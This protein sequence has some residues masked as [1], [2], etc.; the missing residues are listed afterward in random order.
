MGRRSG[1]KLK[2]SDD[3]IYYKGYVVRLFPTPQQEELMWEHVKASRYIWNYMLAKQNEQ[4]EIDGKY[5]S[6][7]DMIKMLTP[8]KKE[9]EHLWLKRVSNASLAQT[10]RDLHAA[11]QHFFKGKF[12]HPQFRR[13]SDRRK[14][15]FPL[16]QIKIDMYFVDE[17]Y[18]KVPKMGRIKYKTNYKFG[19]GRTAEQ[20]TNPRICYRNGKWLLTV[21]RLEEENNQELT[22]DSM[23]IDLGVRKL[24][25]VRYGEETFLFG[26][27][28]NSRKMRKLN[29]KKKHYQRVM[30]RKLRQNG[31]VKSNNYLKYLEK[32][33]KVHA[34][35]SNIKL[36]YIHQITSFLIKKRPRRVVMED[37]K[38][39]EMMRTQKHNRR[40]IS[41]ARW[42]EFIR[43]MK[44]K[45]ERNGI[46]FVSADT[47]FP[48]SQICSVCGHRNR[49][50]K[51]GI[52][53][54]ICPNCFERH[55]RDINAATNLMNYKILES[56]G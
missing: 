4:Q 10:C 17:Q 15:S 40:N 54:W 30:A 31:G 46:E 37:L 24:A 8:L 50:V 41:D 33:R 5:I 42:A 1:Q 12:K 44:Y 36:N 13:Y 9:E 11:Y 38:I 25:V 35:I 53:R 19:F 7:F 45:C 29:N 43:Q 49:S 32:Y 27:I 18:V 21:N 47:F 34:R 52:E 14:Y 51:S 26:N 16:T 3:E 56:I 23:G 39:E 6:E 2:G 55:D 28:N 48:S 20:F 22:K